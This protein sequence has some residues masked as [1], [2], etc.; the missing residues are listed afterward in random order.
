M[1][2]SGYRMQW[3]LRPHF[4]LLTRAHAQDPYRSCRPK[5]TSSKLA[6]Q[7]VQR[8][9]QCLYERF[10]CAQ[11]RLTS[12][13]LQCTRSEKAVS[14]TCM[15]P[16]CISSI[17]SRTASHIPG[18]VFSS[19]VKDALEAHFNSRPEMLSPHF[20]D[21]SILF[22]FSRLLSRSTRFLCIFSAIFSY[23]SFS[24]F[25]SLRSLIP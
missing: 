8:R 3:Y 9:H 16:S 15:S 2:S 5:H 13:E 10:G 11:R 18:A 14:D 21:L 22:F 7:R 6:F 19:P 1:F 12:T 25:A 24:A 4:H 23:R 17:T 20:P